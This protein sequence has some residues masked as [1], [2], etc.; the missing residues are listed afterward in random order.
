MQAFPPKAN[1]PICFPLFRAGFARRS[2]IAFSILWL[3]FSLLTIVQLAGC[4][5]AYNTLPLSVSPNSVSFG[6]VQVGKSQT[7][8]VTLQNQG[9]TAVT[10]SGMQVADPAFALSS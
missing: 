7:T 3:A 5:I 8:T 10:L 2:S 1:R 4:G 9:L 6:T